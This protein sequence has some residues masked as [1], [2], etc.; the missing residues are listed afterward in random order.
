MVVV[1]RRTRFNSKSSK[2]E[3]RQSRVMVLCTIMATFASDN[4]ST[5][6]FDVT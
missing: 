3:E 4:R 2:G 1:K 6:D 5:I